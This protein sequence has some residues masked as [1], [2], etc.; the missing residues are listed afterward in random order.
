[1][2]NAT[3]SDVQRFLFER[4]TS[5]EAL[6]TVIWLAQHADAV[7]TAAELSEKLG[8]SDHAVQEALDALV[9]AELVERE[10]PVPARYRYHARRPELDADLQRMLSLVEEDQVGVACM[11]ASNAIHRVRWLAYLTYARPFANR[12]SPD[13]WTATTARALLNVT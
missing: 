11:L 7:V 1:M 4:V 5:H 13:T 9:D 6:R 3:I 12:R 8:I 10:G 2:A